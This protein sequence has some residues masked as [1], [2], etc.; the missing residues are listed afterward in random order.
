M[1]ILERIGMEEAPQGLKTL[2]QG[3]LEARV[4]REAKSALQRLTTRGVAGKR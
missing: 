3:M 1:A 2:A 4:T